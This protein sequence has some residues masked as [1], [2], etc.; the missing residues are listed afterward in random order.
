MNMTERKYKL[1]CYVNGDVNRKYYM[2]KLE[3]MTHKQAVTMKSKFSNPERVFLFEV[4]VDYDSPAEKALDDHWDDVA[5]E[6]L[7]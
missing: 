3:P 6:Y 1:G 5:R 4:G 7:S 2:H